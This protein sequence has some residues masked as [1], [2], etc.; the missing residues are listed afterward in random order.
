MSGQA[1]LYEIVKQHISDGIVSGTFTPGSK[2][3]SESELVAALSVS[4]MTVNRALRELTRDGVIY[5]MQGV[6]SFVSDAAPSPSLVEIRDIREIIKE[7]G[8]TYSCKALQIQKVEA[9]EDIADLLN[10]EKQTPVISAT[11][12]HFEDSKP[13]QLERRYVR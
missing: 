10:V 5:R 7:R 11:I 8:G 4:R 1:P 6:G 13:L 3:P 9:S 2:L 12:V